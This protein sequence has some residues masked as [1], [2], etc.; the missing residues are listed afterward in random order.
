MY[1]VSIITIN[2]NNCKGLQRT[3]QSVLSQTSQE[4]EYIIIDGNSSDGSKDIIY[5]LKADNI[6]AISESDKGLFNAM[7]K[8][9][10]LSHGE[11][12]LFLNSGD[13]LADKDV[14]KDI[15]KFTNSAD[16]I[17]GDTLCVLDGVFS[18]KWIAPENITINTFYSGSLCHQS[19]F[20][21]REI[22]I[23]RP[24]IET[25]F[26]C[27]DRIHFLQTLFYDNISYCPFHRNIS[28]FD[29]SGI[30]SSIENKMKKEFELREN[31]EKI[32]PKTIL[33]DYD[34]FIGNRTEM[35]AW[36]YSHRNSKIVH[37]FSF[38]FKYISKIEKKIGI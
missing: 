4:Y 23:K 9:V 5:K 32:L 36:A 29:C 1:K 28:I 8:G 19:T 34:N 37:F 15:N 16:L 3:I 30:S 11:Y 33:N 7:N 31:L 26:F 10:K 27:S 12:V 35:E 6:V 24:Y 18:H 38:L 14:I 17:S 13:L 2:L 25:N 20:I 21:R 22:L